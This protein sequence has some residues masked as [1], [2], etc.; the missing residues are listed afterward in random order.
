MWSLSKRD[1]GFMPNITVSDHLYNR[2]FICYT[3]GGGGV[4]PRTA[5]GSP[6]HTCY[7]PH[8]IL[9]IYF[10]SQISLYPWTFDMNMLHQKVFP[11][12]PFI[13]DHSTP[14]APL[15]LLLLRSNLPFHYCGSSMPSWNNYRT[16][17]WG[18]KSLLWCL[19]HS[20]TIQHSQRIL[21]VH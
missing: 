17:I 19:L 14:R 15:P 5:S 12:V 8:L 11:R 6:L 2:H 13:W 4:T 18:W 9:Y 7:Q 3:P 16:V 10:N 21:I 1:H 20:S